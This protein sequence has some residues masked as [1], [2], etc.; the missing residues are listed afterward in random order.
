M[1][2]RLPYGYVHE[3][4][5][6]VVEDAALVRARMAAMLAEIPG[7]HAVIE[8]ACTA[9]AL[10]A[11]NVWTPRVVVLDVHLGRENGLPFARVLKRQ[12]PEAL[13]IVVTNQPSALLRTA[14]F[15]LGADHFFDKSAEF[16]ALARVVA[17]AARPTRAVETSD[18]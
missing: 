13:L 11:L 8:A 2:S 9:Q 3:V 6:L 5:V 15:A 7:V 12:R 14:C 18:A 10:D 1:S 16:E 17:A 4:V